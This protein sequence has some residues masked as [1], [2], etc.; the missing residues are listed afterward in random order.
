MMATKNGLRKEIYRIGKSGLG[1]LFVTGLISLQLSSIG[2]AATRVNLNSDGGVSPT[3]VTQNQH[4]DMEGSPYLVEAQ[5][6]VETGVVLTV[7]PGVSVQVTGNQGIRVLGALAATE[8]SFSG[9]EGASWRGVYFGVDAGASVLDGCLVKDSGVDL[10]IVNGRWVRAALY[11]DHCSPTVRNSAIEVVSGN[12]IELYDS[13]AVITGNRIT[14][15]S[16]THHAV[17]IET[18]DSFPTLSGNS[19]YGGGVLG[20]GLPGGRIQRSGAW[21]Q[22]GAELPYVL[23][24][25]VEVTTDA[26]L[27]I[28]PGTLIQS[29]SRNWRVYGNLLVNGTAEAPVRFEGPWAG[30]YFG[31]TSS[32]SRLVHCEIHDGGASDSGIYNGA[33]RRAAVYLD[34]ASP[35]F[36]NVSVVGSGRHGFELHESSPTL[37]QCLISGAAANGLVARAGSRPSIS[38]TTFANNGG[39][40]AYAVW[41]DA[42]SVPVPSDLTF[43]DNL[44]NGVEV[45]GGIMAE[46]SRWRSWG[47]HTPYVITSNVTVELGKRWEIDPGVMVKLQTSLIRVDGT[48]SAMGSGAQPILFASAKDDTVG[49]DSNGDADASVP[50]PGD[51]KG[52]H[53]S[54]L[55][56]E[57][58]LSHVEFRHGGGDS[59]GIINGAWRHTT[60]YL[61]ESDPVIENVTI[62]NSRADGIEL[63]QSSATIHGCEFTNM[64]VDGYAIRMIA[65]VSYPD[66]R[67]NFG[68][69]QGTIGVAL[70]VANVEGVGRTTR[71]GESFFYYPLGDLTVVDNAT[72]TLDPGVELRFGNGKLNV[73]GS[74]KALGEEG[75][76]VRLQS[77]APEPMAG[78]W[79]GVY[80]GPTSSESELSFV[81]IRHAGRNDLGIY[82]GQWRQAAVYLDGAGP[83]V[84]HLLVADSL[85]NG[86]ELVAASPLL[87]N[88]TLERCQ[89]YA[90]V[91]RDNS[92]PVLENAVFR[93]NGSKGHYT[94]WTDPTSVPNPNGVQFV[95]NAQPGVE[96]VLGTIRQET[97]WEHWGAG[98]PY[99][100]SGVVTV[101]PE[102]LLTVESGAVVKFGSTR[103]V[104]HGTLLADGGEGQIFF[105]ALAN[106]AIGGDTNG[107]GAASE[108]VAGNWQ[109]IY[110][111]PGAGESL[112]RRCLLSYAGGDSLGVINGAWRRDTIYIDQSHP[113]LLH[114]EIV[115]GAGHGVELFSSDA[116]LRHNVIRQTA[117]DHYPILFGNL[118]CFPQL[119][120]NEG[121]ENGGYGV[122]LS[123]GSLARSG[124][125]LNA[126][127]GLPYQPLGDVSSAAG[128]D[129][130][131]G[132]GTRFEIAGARLV[133]EGN[134][135]CQGTPGERV[136]FGG[137][138]VG[139]EFRNW[140]GIYLGAGASD[141]ALDFTEI[142]DAGGN[143]LGVY[144]GRWRR[145]SL[146]A[147]G[148]AVTL[149]HVSVVGG[150]GNGLEMSGA[151]LVVEDSLIAGNARAGVE[152]RG[153]AI[154]RLTNLTIAGN[155]SNGI[156]TDSGGLTLENSIVALNG[157]AGL[158]LASD[159]LFEADRT[160][161]NLFFE[162]AGGDEALWLKVEAGGPGGNL[163]QDPL[164]VNPVVGDYRLSD[165]S[166]AI[167]AGR[168]RDRY[169][170]DLDGRVRWFG[171][172][173]DLGAYEANAV[174]PNYG[175][176][177]AG[178][179][180][181]NEEWIGL[182]VVGED[183]Q[184]IDLRIPVG[185]ERRWEFRY[186]YTGNVPGEARLT[187]GFPAPGWHL[188]IHLLGVTG[189]TDVTPAWFADG[190]YPVGNGL[191]GEVVEF[192]IRLS[193]RADEEVTPGWTSQVSAVSQAGDR[194]VLHLRVDLVEPPRITQHPIAQSAFEAHSVSLTVAAE[195]PGELR[196]Q[197]YRNGTPIAG[198]VGATFSLTSAALDDAGDYF[199]EVSNAD[200]TVRSESIFLEVIEVPDV[201]PEP[202]SIERQP[203]TQIVDEFDEALFSVAVNGEAPLR[204][205][206]Y[207]DDQLLCGETDPE[208]RFVAARRSQQGVY[209]VE[210]TDA[211]G[212]QVTSAKSSELIVEASE[213]TEETVF[214]NN[215]IGAVQNGPTATI[216][217]V[218][219]ETV[220]LTQIETYHWNHAQGRELGTISLEDERGVIY[221]PWDA[222]GRCGQG[223]VVDAYWSVFP[224]VEL[225]PGVYTIVDSDPETW[226]HNGESGGRGFA[227]VRGVLQGAFSPGG[228][229]LVAATG[230]DGAWRLSGD[231]NWF[232][233]SDETFTPG[234]AMRSGAITHGQRSAMELTLTGPGTFSFAWKVS[235]E[236]PDPLRFLIDGLEVARISEERD[237]QEVSFPLRWGERLLTW[238][239]LKDV[240]IDSGADAG[241]VDTVRYEPV[242]LF[243]IETVLT[244]APGPVRLSGPA[245]WFGQGAERFNDQPTVQTGNITHG[246]STR[247]SVSVFGPGWLRFVWKSSTENADRM[248]VLSNGV[249]LAEI[250]GETEWRVEEHFLR[251]GEQHIDFEF[252]KD[253]SV[254][255]FR[256]AGWLADLSFEPVVLEELGVALD[257]P[258]L[259]WTTDPDHPW[260][261]QRQVALTEGASAQSGNIGAGQVAELSALIEGPA[262]LAFQWKASSE[263]ADRGTFW[264]E[265]QQKATISGETEWLPDAFSLG[266]GTH[267]VSW[268]YQKDSSVDTAMDAIF[269]DRVRVLRGNP[270]TDEL[271]LQVFADPGNGLTAYRGQ[272]GR[273][274]LFRLTGANEGSLWGT[275]TYTDD[276][277]LRK[278]AVHAGA[279][280]AGESGVVRVTILAGEA[281]YTGSVRNGVSSSGFGS[282][283]GSFRVD[284]ITDVAI[285]PPVLAIQLLDGGEVEVSWQSEDPM[286]RLETSA[287]L[288]ADAWAEVSGVTELA[289]GRRGVVISVDAFS[290]FFQLVR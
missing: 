261:G 195:G 240:S 252:A 119:I 74:L 221:G 194:D 264:I 49:G 92:R 285:E 15:A 284:A 149:R 106:D 248:R 213:L 219:E 270:S 50:E 172:A 40:G 23:H 258:D 208:L 279:I 281:T 220:W 263:T 217:F 196:Y 30:F 88:V 225:V 190:G 210:I 282:W 199:V 139:E 52:I 105:T 94:V 146:Y 287:T 38:G 223:G 83:R 144:D 86:L 141:S 178:R 257:A 12:G 91:A 79:K 64:G 189:E 175:G 61:E 203:E 95:G 14:V 230:L 179:E 255:S 25:A 55:S 274:L 278:A 98:V 166:A 20:I 81:E 271:G 130:T 241:W 10:G 107:D 209:W 125:W 73:F 78:D 1:R 63:Y 192:E 8:A 202:L 256:D 148:A 103:L 229:D 176:D 247:L 18:M 54:P 188:E 56:T 187:T 249:R 269:L 286:W 212:R 29:P 216:S 231:A 283:P 228:P 17:W 138:T 47:P 186:E 168:E 123:P 59:V 45:A 36:E 60:L 181:G 82:Q 277:M 33:W 136:V 80:F 48:L 51:W 157:A 242:P 232:A 132:P 121:I 155:G 288:P 260:F 85:H 246:E 4:W 185:E 13:D 142:R 204:Y 41:M 104:V 77:R 267:Q 275:D 133:F 72:W 128:V 159:A 171:S 62:R 163:D 164:F 156:L 184:S 170:L 39:D 237:W 152:I 218:V 266:T 243:D 9:F 162:N 226:S 113:S 233:Q 160:W 108:P 34:H 26:T 96:I 102:I 259:E 262:T 253:S 120:G 268:R 143:D 137:R 177:L 205:Q 234:T 68:A 75:V 57:S 16:E 87:R 46:D 211:A 153:T 21:T 140:K 265:G 76:P 236:R 200:G 280:A 129:L 169:G 69:G 58:H 70:P 27:T 244:E 84:E 101:D 215:N 35:T 290:A 235:S 238:E 93:E 32:G 145:A 90:L 124:L 110:L 254:D 150:G 154:P 42:T 11:L 182:G 201:E 273:V 111:G 115:H 116:V 127:P 100:V 272:I 43:R 109:G 22:A 224:D 222:T 151:E 167:D 126:G 276:S 118:D 24:G 19:G 239:Y 289:G 97:L 173:V 2:F 112:L 37:N 214:D 198:A 227:L 183:N 197:W 66:L 31:A 99:V 117:P 206:W 7:D 44:R 89:R 131:V 193:P 114:N 134:L 6:T 135:W 180:A 245:P 122:G 174:E 250:S 191:P 53:F 207:R 67:D 71:A 158:G 65:A 165:L 147:A 3:S 251:W 5:L 28:G 161:H